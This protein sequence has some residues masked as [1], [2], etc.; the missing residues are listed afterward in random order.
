MSPGAFPATVAKADGPAEKPK[1]TYIGQGEYAIDGGN[2][3]IVTLLGSCVS[4][5]IWDPDRC[6][7]G[8]NH[9]LFTDDNVNAAEVFGHGVNGME[10]LINGL[11]RLGA[12]RKNLRAKIFGGAKMI[13]RLSDEGARNGEFVIG[14]LANEGIP[15]LGGDLGGHRA[16]RIEF[17]PGSGRARLK[18]V[19]QEV[20]VRHLS[21]QRQTNAV[22]LF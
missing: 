2:A 18:Y 20:K 10:L 13:S 3:V 12:D 14:Y 15:H 7:G 17:W 22:E 8:M 6:I 1:R 19:E 5:C 9:V 21:E 16:R 4:A 11:L